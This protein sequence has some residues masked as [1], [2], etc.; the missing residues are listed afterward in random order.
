MRE[1]L[2]RILVALIGIP[3][4]VFLIWQGGWYFFTL[5]LIIAVS[6]QVEF[7][8]IAKQKNIETQQ[9]MGI[10]LTIVTLYIIQNNIQ[11]YFLI[12]LICITTYIFTVEMFR[13]NSSP[14]FNI[15]VTFLGV[16]YPGIFLGLLLFLR[17]HIENTEISSAPGF[18][19]TLFVAIWA[20]DSFA[21]FVGK[22][23]GKHP[24]FVKVSPKKSIEGSI[25]GLL[26]A[27]IVFLAVYL[28]QWYHIS[29]ELSVLC[30]FV[31]GVFGQIGDL[32]ESWFK[33]D[34]GVKD[35]SHFL[36]G[37]G[38]FLDRFDSL[39]FVS[40]IFFIIYIILVNY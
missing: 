19:I 39:I 8:H 2:I 36:P 6:G 26:G 4:L 14:I 35:S 21:Y 10:I 33:R 3:L 24:L 25:G 22:S 34:T 38:G 23:I 15:A 5:I 37:H 1:L 29:L 32:T 31:V 40:P 7:Y 11:P 18:I 12:V 27:V 13:K 28:Y 30:G 16:I 20:C 9:T 17:N